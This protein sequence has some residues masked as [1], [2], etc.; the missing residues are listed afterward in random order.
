VVFV[1][2]VGDAVGA[3]QLLLRLA[4]QEQGVLGRLVSLKRVPQTLRRPLERRQDAIEGLSLDEPPAVLDDAPRFFG[5]A[6]RSKALDAFGVDH[7][8]RRVWVALGV[9]VRQVPALAA[10]RGQRDVVV[11]VL[12]PRRGGGLE[13]RI[14]RVFAGVAFG[15]DPRLHLAPGLDVLR[16]FRARVQASHDL[17]AKPA[18]PVVRDIDRKAI[19][20]GPSLHAGRARPSRVSGASLFETA[21][22]SQGRLDLSTRA[23][24]T[25]S[26]RKL[27]L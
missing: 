14:V 23:Q 8:E 6:R 21:G 5:G 20:H 11:H 19:R 7:E 3:A 12:D 1:R 9:L 24:R 22:G 2:S 17:R 25:T 4:G 13:D 18:E 26:W 10:G 15:S 16:E 27:V